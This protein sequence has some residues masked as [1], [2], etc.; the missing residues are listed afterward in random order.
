M[1]V[2]T[3]SP[4]QLRTIVEEKWQR[5]EGAVAVGLHVNA[6]WLGPVEV[7]FD[8]GKARVIRADTVFEVREALRDAEQTTGR[9]ILLTRLQQADLGHD[10]VARLARSRLF[11]IDHWASLCALFKAK[12]LDRSIC[13]PAIAQ[14]LIEYAPADGYPP[15]SAG[16]LDGGTV[17]RAINRHVFDMGES[18]PDLVSLLLWA[19]TRSGSTRYASA[20]PELR[21]SLR[22]RLVGN[23]GDAADCILRF[24]ESGAGADALALAV[25]C[26]VVFGDGQDATLEAAAA[27][28]EAFHDN[29]PIPASIGRCL[30]RV[31]SDAVADLDRKDDSGAAHQHLRRAD[32]LLRQFRCEEHAYRNRLTLLAYEQRLTRFG[33]QVEAAIA[34]P[35]EEAILECERFQGKLTDHRVARLGRQQNKIPRTEMALRL[36]RW[37]ARTWRGAP[38]KCS[39]DLPSRGTPGGGAGCAGAGRGSPDPAPDRTEGL[40][41]GRVRAGRG[42]PDPAR[43]P[44]SFPE[45]ARVYRQELA[46]VDWARE[47][48][49]RGEDVAGL[50]RA[51]QRLDQAVLER[52]EAFNKLFAGSLSG[53]TSVGSDSPEVRGVEDVISDVVFK[54]AKAGN[55]VL[56]IVL[57]GMSWAICHE[58][59]DD[60]RRDHWYLA[61]LDDS[62]EPPRPVIATIPSVT[63]FSRT[64]LLSGKIAS[65]DAATETRN[66]ASNPHLEHCSDKRVLPVLFHKKELTDGTRGPLNDE[67]G[68]AILSP[69]HRVVGVVI[70]AIDDRLASAQQIRDDWTID[71]ISP[72]GPLLKLARDTGRVVV[73]ASDHGHVWHR[74]DARNVPIETGGRWRPRNENIAED[75]IALAGKRVH[76]GTSGGSVIVPW[77]ERVYYGRPQNGYHGGATPQEMVCPLVLL[78]DNSSEYSKI[79][80]CDLPKPE[81]WA[82]APTRA[83]SLAEAPAPI[84]MA[85]PRRAPTLFDNLPDEPEEPRPRAAKVAG[86]VDR[87]LASQVYKDQKELIR[88]HAP[89]DEIVRRTLNVLDLNGGVMTPAAF[90][91]AAEIPTPRLDGLMAL[92]QRLLNVDGY[93]ILTLNRNENKIEL[94]VAK[95]RRQFDLG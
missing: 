57:D 79:Y 48:I 83:A 9:I 69:N 3:L 70:N 74:A 49:C 67:L 33:V 94:N 36:V 46:F 35:S 19:T 66:F 1:S 60:L 11:A 93:E 18:E 38:D 21:A 73:L 77:S 7:E 39:E 43:E 40:P 37:L 23:L 81:W 13:D 63:T 50:S 20:S 91:N 75:E 51:Y 10:V 62:M 8:F 41:T 76:G 56:L 31:A 71:R 84:P 34:A 30:G 16:I 32:E 52:R 5:D 59:L 85:S 64:S 89:D 28:M 44:T 87:L 14:A 80:K 90:S 22:Q 26:Q 88:R 58:L 12:E 29:K 2:G 68:Q 53:W 24:I 82:S 45:F 78:I 55:R 25:A 6:S 47:S 65:G 92:I 95:L 27:R 4:L 42:S 86:W 54:V 72:L 15:V 61:T 17:W